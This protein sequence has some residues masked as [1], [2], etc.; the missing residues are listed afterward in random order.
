MEHIK[1]E[2]NGQRAKYS[3]TSK[4]LLVAGTILLGSAGIAQAESTLNANQVI[5]SLADFE[6]I[7]EADK[8]IARQSV[9][10]ENRDLKMAGLVFSPSNID[11]SKKHP[12]IVIV[13][14]GGGIKEQ[15][16]SL[17][18][19]RLAQQGYVVLAF[20]ASYQGASE[21]Q[22]RGLEDPTARVE[23]VR[24]AVDYLTTLSYIDKE[25]IAAL[26]ICAGGGYAISAATTEHRIKA[27]A[28]VSGIDIGS[29]N[30]E[31]WRQ[32]TSVADQVKSLEAVAK[33]RTA[34]ANGAE[35]MLSNYVPETTDQVTEPDM[36]EA[37]EY[38]RLP[39]R[40]L[41]P[42]STNRMVFTSADKLFNFSAFSQIGTLLTQPLL[43]IAGSDSGSLWH[44]QRA[45]KLA[46]GTKELFV[47]KGG[48]HMSLYDRDLVKALPKL[49]SFYQKNLK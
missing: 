37:S 11:Q 10:F 1:K 40:W 17:Y 6:K 48:T 27:V 44:S 23:D 36:V 43:M 31:G 2:S 21:G 19:Y 34:E 9:A 20:D 28:T 46:K 30:R 32:G 29:A 26:G 49:I 38:Y 18:A 8:T 25:R 4:L 5:T 47:I 45:V 16:A 14:P 13:H 3:W 33:Q 15:T 41:H 39:T 42:N 35:V 24:A 22:P 7:V 12:A